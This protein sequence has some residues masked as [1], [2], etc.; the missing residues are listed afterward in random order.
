MRRFSSCSTSVE[1]ERISLLLHKTSVVTKEDSCHVSM[2]T[3]EEF[4]LA[5]QAWINRKFPSCCTRIAT[6]RIFLLL[7]RLFVL[8]N[9]HDH[10]QNFPLAERESLQTECPSCCTRMAYRQT[11]PL[12]KQAWP[13]IEFPSCCT[14]MAREKI[15]LS[16]PS[17]ITERSFPRSSHKHG[18]QEELPLRYCTNTARVS[19]HFS[20]TT[21]EVF[22]YA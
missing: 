17:I 9:K 5:A 10:R 21:R 8:L 4:S 20:S 13:Q 15:S 16:C 7:H 14:S 19:I 6:D 12:A 1:T 2:T 11:F 22:C 18:V 3:A